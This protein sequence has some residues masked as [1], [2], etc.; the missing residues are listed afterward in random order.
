MHTVGFHIWPILPKPVG[1]TVLRRGTLDLQWEH[2]KTLGNK[3]FREAHA[4]QDP[5][6]LVEHLAADR[7][8]Y[9][10]LET[11]ENVAQT[12]GFHN[13]PFGNARTIKGSAGLPSGQSVRDV[14]LQ[15]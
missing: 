10:F 11:F 7:K 4:G 14:L 2:K 1:T 6:R 8:S 12:I 15:T 3:W 9:G 13:W 5:L